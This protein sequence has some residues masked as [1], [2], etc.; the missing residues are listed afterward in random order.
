[1]FEFEVKRI[2]VII[3]YKKNNLMIKMIIK[4]HLYIKSGCIY[5]HRTYVHRP[6]ASNII[7][8]GSSLMVMMM[9]VWLSV[10]AITHG[11]TRMSYGLDAESFPLGEF[12]P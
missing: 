12:R 8:S 2:I 5:N 7:W 10:A 6:I 4:D 1:M 9:K 3:V 11:V